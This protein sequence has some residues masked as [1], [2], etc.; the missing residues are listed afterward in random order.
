[1]YTIDTT[2]VMKCFGEDINKARGW[3]NT[4]NPL[5]GGVSPLDMIILGRGEKLEKFIK[6]QEEAYLAFEKQDD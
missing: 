4:P 6:M 2:H 5:L 1:M 3:F